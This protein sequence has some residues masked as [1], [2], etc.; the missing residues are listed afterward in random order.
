M[1][2]NANN[3]N[4]ATN[5]NNNANTANK[6]NNSNN[7]NNNNTNNGA[8]HSPCTKSFGKMPWTEKIPSRRSPQLCIFG[9]TFPIIIFQE[10]KMI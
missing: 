3:A 2:N 7:A 1:L 10:I 6:I 8:T 4:N 5:A 9:L